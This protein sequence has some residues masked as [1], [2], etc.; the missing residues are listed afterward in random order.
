[1]TTCAARLAV[2]EARELV[3]RTTRAG[4][5]VRRGCAICG[6]HVAGKTYDAGDIVYAGGSSWTAVTTTTAA[7]ST[8]SKDWGLLA[9]RGRDGKREPR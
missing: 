8:A 1:M 5:T 6:V 9:S 7:P 4:K 3:A 2:L